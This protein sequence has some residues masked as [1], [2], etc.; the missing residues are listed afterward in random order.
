LI[1]K[2]VDIFAFP[3]GDFDDGLVEAARK[4]GYRF[5]FSTQPRTIDPR[6]RQALR[7]RVA[8][9]PWD[10]PLEVLAQAARRA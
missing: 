9:N 10:S 1:G 4:A 5:V 6:D 3:Y 2:P 7:A 8:T